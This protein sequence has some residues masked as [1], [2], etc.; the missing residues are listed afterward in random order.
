MKMCRHFGKSVQRYTK[1]EADL[2]AL[3]ATK[4]GSPKVTTYY[5]L[6]LKGKY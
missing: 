1:N 6:I 2:A 3:S 4:I 5:L